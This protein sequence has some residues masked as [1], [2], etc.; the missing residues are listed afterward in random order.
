M[1]Q[2][3]H[4]NCLKVIE[5]YRDNGKSTIWD[6]VLP[7]MRGGEL[8]EK[9]KHGPLEEP[10]AQVVLKQVNSALT[11]LHGKGIVH[12]DL[13]P[14]NVMFESESSSNICLADFGAAGI[15]T[16]KTG[17][18]SA[19]DDDS[20]DTIVGTAGY[21]APEVVDLMYGGEG[22]GRPS[23]MWSFG[24]LVYLILCGKLPCDHQEVDD[25]V[26]EF[27]VTALMEGGEGSSPELAELWNPISPLAKEIV[28]LTLVVDPTKR[29][30][31]STVESHAWFADISWDGVS[32]GGDGFSLGGV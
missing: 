30:T 11:Y 27:D 23:D 22:Y 13:K 25:P 5:V 21:I 4:P 31:A 28:K 12:R 14:E 2:L 8:Y 16:T 15:L 9:I 3:D 10:V 17:D 26:P 32:A 18:E 7:L 24:V 1:M 20:L 19:F 6:L 29:V